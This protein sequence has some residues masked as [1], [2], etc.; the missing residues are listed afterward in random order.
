MSATGYIYCISNDINDNKYIGKTVRSITERFQ[1]HCRDYKKYSCEQRPLYNAMQK[2][3]I[4][5]FF[6]EQIEEVEISQLEERE[7]YWISKLN[8]YKNGYNA[9][10]GGD[11]HLLYDYNAM[12]NDYKDGMLVKEIAKKY[13]CDERTATIA[14]QAC[15]LNGRVNAT[16]KSKHKI[17]QLDLNKNYV[18][19]FDSQAEAA[20][21]LIKNGS[22][23]GQK[24]LVSN[25]G[26][27]LKNKRKT[28]EGYIWEYDN[29]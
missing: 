29:S 15:G 2:Y 26:R 11:G 12:A 6:V 22:K 3:G 18:Q 27:V 5:H 25:I 16:N 14:L 7:Q 21:W 20:D 8:T 17:K 1:E 13:G 23:S 24:A 28:C 9:T 19:T 4:E 10:I